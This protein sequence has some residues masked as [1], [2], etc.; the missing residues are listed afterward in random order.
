[1]SNSQRF[2]QTPDLIKRKE[3]KVLFFS[4]LEECLIL[5]ISIISSFFSCG[6][7]AQVI[8]GE[9]VNNQFLKS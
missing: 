8:I 2:S 3:D 1:M 7:I 9:P 4:Y 5:I 6:R